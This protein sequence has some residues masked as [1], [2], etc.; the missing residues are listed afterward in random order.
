MPAIVG[1]VG[2]TGPPVDR[3]HLTNATKI[4]RGIAEAGHVVLTGGHADKEEPSVKFHAL[5]G[6][7]RAA[8]EGHQV[9]MVGILPKTV[10]GHTGPEVEDWTSPDGDARGA[11]LYTG[12]TSAERCLISGGAPDALIALWGTGGTAKEVAAALDAGRPVVFVDSFLELEPLVKVALGEFGVQAIPGDL[13]VE[14]TAARAVDEALG[15][16]V[17]LDPPRNPP[18]W[19]AK[20]PDLHKLYAEA[21]RALGL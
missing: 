17:G 21:L 13:V 4:G 12:L 15:A 2:K 7:L 10:A 20:Y 3:K 1:I 14:T 16:L 5:L 8:D 19:I 18:R 11:F 6:V 9:R